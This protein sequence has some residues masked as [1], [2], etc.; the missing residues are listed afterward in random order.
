MRPMFVIG[1]Y[2]ERPEEA[3]LRF[4]DK[5]REWLGQDDASEF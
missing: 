5:I 3:V 4:V 1:T 2:R